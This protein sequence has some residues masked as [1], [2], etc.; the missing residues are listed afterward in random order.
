MKIL[1]AYDGLD[2]S[3][4]ALEE[5]AELAASGEADVTI[6]SVVAESEARASKAGGHRWLAPHAHE[7]VAVA[8]K[9]LSERGVAAEMKILYGDPVE[10]IRGEALEGSYDLIVAG[11]RELGPIG[12]VVL[13]SVS[14]RLVN[15]A[16]CPVLVAGE[17][18]AIRHEPPV[19][20]D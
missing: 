7:D 16:P 6:L 10:V 15:S 19:S 4:H 12:R 14:R 17:S 13:G 2:R 11:S 9:Y 18:V 20:V 3:R 8:H 1:L 5:A